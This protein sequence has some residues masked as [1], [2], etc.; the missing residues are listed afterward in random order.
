VEQGA[1]VTNGDSNTVSIIDTASRKIAKA[2]VVARA[3]SF[4]HPGGERLY[5]SNARDTT[6]TVLAIPSLN[7]L[8]TIR[9]IETRP[10]TSILD[11]SR[12]IK[13]A[14]TQRF[15]LSSERRSRASF[16]GKFSAV[17]EENT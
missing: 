4:S 8:R 14:S 16:A 12:Q 7:V 3:R 5:V 2:I 6:I 11:R 15:H 9:N 1:F 17:C 13:V 10:L